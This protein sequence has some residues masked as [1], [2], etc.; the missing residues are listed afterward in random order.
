[1]VRLGVVECLFDTAQSVCLIFNIIYI[2]STRY[3]AALR[4]ASGLRCAC[5]PVAHPRRLLAETDPVY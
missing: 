3:Y 2:V 5:I 4:Y 1:M